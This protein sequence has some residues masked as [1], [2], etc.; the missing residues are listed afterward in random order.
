MAGTRARCAEG[1]LVY[2][3]GHCRKPRYKSA[4]KAKFPKRPTKAFLRKNARVPK[5]KIPRA[6]RRHPLWTGTGFRVPRKHRK[7]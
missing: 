3:P 7:R 1:G 4:G 5:V 6:P 2:V